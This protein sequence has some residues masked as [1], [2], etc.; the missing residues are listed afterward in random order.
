MQ[1]EKRS[2]TLRSRVNDKKHVLDRMERQATITS[3]MLNNNLDGRTRSSLYKKQI[4]R[5]RTFI[6]DFN[7]QNTSVSNA[8]MRHDKQAIIEDRGNS[9]LER[10][11]SVKVEEY[12]QRKIV[13][14]V[15]T[16][17]ISAVKVFESL[18]N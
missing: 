3:Q 2:N 5:E 7:V 1:D 14:Q 18:R 11:Q 16:I 12:E 4:Y 10:V 8:L 6:N 17:L 15:I 13:S 9:N